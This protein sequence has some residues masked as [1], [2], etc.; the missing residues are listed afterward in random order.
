LNGTGALAG[1]AVMVMHQ[2]VDNSPRSRRSSS[3]ESSDTARL[4]FS[5]ASKEDEDSSDN[6]LI[7]EDDPQKA[8]VVSSKKVRLNSPHLILQAQSMK[9]ISDLIERPSAAV[10]A[11]SDSRR[12][13]QTGTVTQEEFALSPR[14]NREVKILNMKP[15]TVVFSSPRNP[16]QAPLIG[17]LSQQ[18]H[19]AMKSP[20]NICASSIE[21]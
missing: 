12:I 21:S 1:A 4:S 20:S 16:I 10:Q 5:I 15:R 13:M 18:H 2:E 17:G 8:A 9:S 11:A 7:P 6:Y 3:R 14:H 19:F